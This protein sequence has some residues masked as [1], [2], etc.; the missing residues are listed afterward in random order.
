[1][2]VGEVGVEQS[3]R[4]DGGG[5]A[6]EQA[7]EDASE[8]SVGTLELFFDL[9]FVYAMSQVTVLMLAH[10]SWAGF[11]RGLLTLGAVWWAWVCYAWLT[12]I[13]DH[14]GSAHRL[15]IFL[16]MAAMLV[17]AVG[18][19]QAFG[20]RALVFGLAFLA[21]RL[22]HVA[23]LALDVR[24]EA[25]VGAAALRLVPTLLIGPALL[26]AAAFVDTPGRELLWIAAA[27]IDFS[28][29][30]LVGTAG[31]G[32]A[33]SYVVE[34]H[35]QII[36]IA[37]GEA[38]VEVGAGAKDSLGRPVVVIAVLLA[39]L[40]AAGLWSS[41]FGYL[42]RGAERRLRGTGDRERARL[43]RDSYSYLHLPLVAG[44]VFFALR[45]HEAVADAARPLPL[46]S[47]VALA[48]GVALFFL[49]DVAYRWRDHH[50]LAVDRLLAGVGASVL[51]PVA[52][53]APALATL[54]GLLL[55]C[56]LQTSW[57]LWRHPAIGPVDS[58]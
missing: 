33:P 54:A 29:P 15:L 37:L 5:G 19:P 36:I 43:A 53:L 31:W 50:Q 35:G 44:V 56:L 25:D 8:R 17:A 23:L 12:N 58:S 20:A 46:L 2:E 24:A 34:R 42:R 21:V 10:I 30:V 9:V 49:G 39:V 11:G 27:V 16:A 3:M 32:V 45:V 51:I 47:A 41:Y 4:D 57:E 48:G 55:V 13:S 52:V 6:G 26:V 40:I 22:I 18:L 1:M 38:I 14:A 28:G 7:A